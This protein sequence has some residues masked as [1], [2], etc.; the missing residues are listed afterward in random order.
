MLRRKALRIFAV[1]A[2]LLATLSPRA[3]DARA[4]QPSPPTSGS[5][6]ATEA[7]Y[8]VYDSAGRNVKLSDVV[9]AMSRADVLFVGETH[10]DPLAHALEAELLREAYARF[11]SGDESARRPV[12]LA[13]EMFERDVQVVVDEYLAGLITERHFLASS[14]PWKNYETDYK[15]LV[16]F[17][18]AHR[19][20]VIAANAPARYVA[21][22]SRSGVAS[23]QTL[24]Q[25]ARA[26]L[27]PLPFAS[28][29]A[30]YAAKFARA[31]G[32]DPMHSSA[33][34]LDAQN[35]RDATMAYAV[36]EHLK[37]E[38]KAFVLHVNGK[39]HSEERLGV[40]EHLA[41]YRPLSRMLV[42]TLV[43]TKNF[44]AFDAANDGRLGDFVIITDARLPRSF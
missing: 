8:R 7:H 24:S 41:R 25:Q 34:L 31:M 40:P 5:G 28:A 4:Q 11:T 32:G 43:A 19:L 39:F 35:L 16:E 2:L 42:V 44:P 6:R 22:A 17:A 37:R 14:R 21:L 29:S 13:L 38:Q 10:D 15:P 12:A 9:E 23:L 26:W 20:G 3:S 30:P 33:H 1:S 27:A 18:R 36:S